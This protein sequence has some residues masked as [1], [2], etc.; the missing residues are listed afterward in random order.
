M[1]FDKI[2]E[3][4]ILYTYH[5]Y[6]MGNTTI[7]ALGED[8]HHVLVKEAGGAWVSGRRGPQFVRAYELSKMKTW[9]AY[10]DCALQH[11]NFVGGLSKVTLKP[12]H[13][14]PKMPKIQEV[15]Q[16]Q[17]DAVKVEQE[18]RAK[19]EK[20]HEEWAAKWAKECES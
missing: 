9:G 10:D 4:A 7:S 14:A 12:G 8:S 2:P 20:E 18:K 1:K 17:R 3:G 15:T 6:K 5:R 11:R 19:A 13:K 16:A